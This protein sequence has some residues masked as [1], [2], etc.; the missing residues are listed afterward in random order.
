VYPQERVA[1][2][3]EENFIPVR[4]HVLEQRE[5]FQRVGE[6]YGALWTPSLLE[7]DSDGKEHHRV[8]GFLEADDLLAQLK[9][10][11][12]KIAFHEKRW[13]D[14]ERLFEEVIDEHGDTDAAAEALYWAGVSRYKANGDAAELA[15]TAAAFTTRYQDSTWAKKSSIWKADAKAAS[16]TP[17]AAEPWPPEPR[18]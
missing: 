9:L 13:R 7:L 6:R 8:E 1:R 16:V 14:A 18:A 4:L 15:R 17:R 2:F 11:L 3:I 10:G 5:D 12:G